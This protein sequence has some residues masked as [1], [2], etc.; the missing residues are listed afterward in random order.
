VV[1]AGRGV[2]SADGFTDV[3][4]LTK[5]VDGA[6]GVSRVVT[7]LGW[8]P[9]HEQVGQTG[10][11]IT[12]DLYIPCG[13]SGAIQHWAG[14]SSAKTILAINTDAEAP[15]VTRAHYAVIGDLHEIVPAINEEIRRRKG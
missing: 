15:M 3:L 2:G 14:V 8:R 6:L 5:L 7:S 12:P 1:G 4:E 11:R 10:S 9:H 13:I